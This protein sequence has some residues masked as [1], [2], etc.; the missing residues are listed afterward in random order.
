MIDAELNFGDR[1]LGDVEK[2]NFIAG[3]Q[4]KSL[5]QLVFKRPKLSESFQ[6]K[7]YKG[8]VRV[9]GVWSAHGHSS[10]WLVVR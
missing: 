9:R 3:C 10:D 1:V 8:R 2:N 6:G 5:G 7:V 4:A